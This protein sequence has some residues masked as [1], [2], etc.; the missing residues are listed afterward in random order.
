MST[1][2]A[3]AKPRLILHVGHPKTGTTT[4]QRTLK[5]AQKTLLEEFGLLYPKAARRMNHRWLMPYLAPTGSVHPRIRD[6]LRQDPRADVATAAATH[7]AAACDEV[8]RKRPQTVLLSA[9][10]LF[11]GIQTKSLHT[12][13]TRLSD[14]SDEVEI[15]VYLRD[16][17][18]T[19]ISE[20]QQRV[21]HF[22]DLRHP[23]H[24]RRRA[25]MAALENLSTVPVQ[26]RLFDRG[27]LA[28][29][30]IVSDFARAVLP[31]GAEAA[32]LAVRREDANLSDSGE[33]MALLQRFHRRM[34]FAGTAAYDDPRAKA[35]RDR[36]SVLDRE[37]PGFDKP[38]PAAWLREAIEREDESLP[39][40]RHRYG[41]V[42]PKVDYAAAGQGSAAGRRRLARIDV[43][44][45]LLD[46]DPE[47]EASLADALADIA[48]CDLR[49]D[50]APA[51]PIRRLFTRR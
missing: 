18:E 8:R 20:V 34:A 29:G 33:A 37:T 27:A 49:P 44:G 19:Y 39:W 51:H 11:G 5:A 32:L 6:K 10:N 2:I 50:P 23:S 22:G 9:E 26:A 48:G 36:L 35:V 47:R 15:V 43:V 40:L 7:W 3:V 21:R 45:D 13:R 30:D 46:L 41:V 31:A 1:P 25:A 38:R 4:L 17:T 42:F 28:G 16:P 12:T 14:I 24:S